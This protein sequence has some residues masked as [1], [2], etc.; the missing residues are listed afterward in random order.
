MTD[1]GEPPAPAD[2]DAELDRREAASRRRRHFRQLYAIAAVV[3]IAVG[4]LAWATDGFTRSTGKLLGSLGPQC[5][6][7]VP[8]NGSGS[9]FVAPLMQSWTTAYAG[10]AASRN[11]GCVVVQ[12]TYHATGSAA[13]L[14]TLGADGTEFTTTEEPLTAAAEALLPYPTVTLPL[15][16]SAVA[17][18][19]NLPGVGAGLNL[20]GPVLAGIYLGSITMWN[21]PKITGMNSGVALPPGTPIAVLHGG[22]GS[23]TNFVFTSFLSAA[24]TTWATQVGAGS[25]VTWPVGA[26][27][28]GDAAAA[29]LLSTTPGGIA[30]LGL[31][32]AAGAGLT[33]AKI[34][35][36]AG[37]FVA[38]SASGVYAAA[39][40]YTAALPAGNQSWQNVTLLDEPGNA[41]YPIT[42]FSYA[43]VYADLGQAYNGGMTLHVA[44]WLAA[45]LFWMSVAGQTY[46]T[47]LGF[48]PFAQ[49]VTLGNAQIV[50][51]L[52]YDGTQ[53]LGDVDYDGD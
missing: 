50:E 30:F 18:A 52:T 51:L 35:N 42:T 49:K 31:A 16:V 34:E 6:P 40:A 27:A 28:D 23:S 3:L 21:D 4:G 37:V 26:T 24:N 33:C 2:T 25:T 48:A 19:Y 12:P 8:L 32:S 10:A 41:S 1:P 17:V 20:T 11:Q 7:T 47:A 5:P 38:P 9:T 36:P 39:T 14:A 22:A 46:G 44:Q 53:V 13:G 15:G 29:S 43:I 45:F